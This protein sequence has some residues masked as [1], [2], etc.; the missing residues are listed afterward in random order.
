MLNI[1]IHE[2]WLLLC[3]DYNKGERL[4]VIRGAVPSNLNN[5]EGDAFAVRN[6]YALNVDFIDEPPMYQISPTHFVKSNLLNEK[7][8]DYEPPRVIKNLWAKYHSTLKSIY[9]DSYFVDE[10]IYNHYKNKGWW[11]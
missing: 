2:V 6:D 10:V 11:T 9:G 1:L 8:P 4:Q 5:I 7:A 3:L